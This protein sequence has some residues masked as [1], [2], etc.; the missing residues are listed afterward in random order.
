M[1]ETE[2][3]RPVPRDDK[4]NGRH[5]SRQS[6]DKGMRPKPDCKRK[7]LRRYLAPLRRLECALCRC[8]SSRIR[9]S[10][11]RR[12]NM[13][14]T[15]ESLCAQKHRKSFTC[16]WGLQKICVPL[17]AARN[18]WHNSFHQAS[19]LLEPA[20]SLPSPDAQTGGLSKCSASISNTKRI[21]RAV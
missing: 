3:A 14:A 20:A 2:E 6:N 21:L 12:K 13:R 16:H 1:L 15:S 4:T 7:G 11:S 8:R 17:Q 5:V 19:L 18:S 10:P 9:Q